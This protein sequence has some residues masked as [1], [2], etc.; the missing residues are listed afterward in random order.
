MLIRTEN[1][2]PVVRSAV[3][4]DVKIRVSGIII[5]A[6]GVTIRISSIT[7]CRVPILNSFHM[8]HHLLI[9]MCLFTPCCRQQINKEGEYIESED[10][11]NNPLKHGSDILLLSESSCSEDDGETDF[12]KNENQLHPE[13]ETQNAMLA[14]VDAETLIF[15][16]YEDSA[17]D[18][19]GDEEEEE[20]VMK[21]GVV[22]G[23]EDGE[24]D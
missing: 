18:V 15:G 20:A 4:I 14:E 11:R 24:E 16:T 23:I 10:E 2:T 3:I 8:L 6:V 1:S 17:D 7:H 21:M 22:E 9:R 13:A 12:H 19:A 5:G